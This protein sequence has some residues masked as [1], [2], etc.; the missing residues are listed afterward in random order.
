MG[1]GRQ[2]RNDPTRRTGSF[3]GLE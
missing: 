3:P 1:Q 2:A